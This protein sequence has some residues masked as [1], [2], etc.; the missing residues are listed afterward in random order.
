MAKVNQIRAAR[1]LLGW[2]QKDLARMA[3]ISELSVINI[4]SGKTSPQKNTLD[5]IILA[6]ELAGVSFTENGVEE[7]VNIFTAFKEEDWYLKMLEDVENSFGAHPDTV[8]DCILLYPDDR[9]GPPSVISKVRHLRSK[10][11]KSR[12]FIKE[13]NTYIRGP[14]PEYRYIPKEY[15]DDDR[16]IQCYA[17][18]VAIIEQVKK[19]SK[20][21][22]RDVTVTRVKEEA[23]VSIFRNAE[24]ANFVSGLA[25][26][27]WDILPQPAKT[28]AKK[29][30]LY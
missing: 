23:Q 28:T 16:L 20:D 30:D 13:G 19:A 7:K 2:N 14:L 5:K 9:L 24:L 12:Y 27:L 18:K 22:G 15:F 4:E 21:N 26:L 10:G 17:D 29:H 6:F 1:G 25:N 3:G 11:V 8:N